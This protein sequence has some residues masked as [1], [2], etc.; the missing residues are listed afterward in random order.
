MHC[1]RLSLHLIYHTNRPPRRAFTALALLA[2]RLLRAYLSRFEIESGKGFK[3]S[4]TRNDQESVRVRSCNAEQLG[5][6]AE[7]AHRHRPAPR[8]VVT[9]LDL[10]DWSA[11]LPPEFLASRENPLPPAAAPPLGML[12]DVLP[13]LEPEVVA[14]PVPPEPAYRSCCRMRLKSCCSQFRLPCRPS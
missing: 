14:P 8:G 4:R 12:P 1:H 2:A 6:Q 3:G 9:E 5:A 7:C 10:A 13:A 11:G